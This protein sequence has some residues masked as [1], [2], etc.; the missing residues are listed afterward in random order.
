MWPWTPREPVICE[1]H[2]SQSRLLRRG[3][4]PTALPALV[5][6]D[7]SI[8]VEAIRQVTGPG[9]VALR[10]RFAGPRTVHWL[11][12]PPRGSGSLSDWQL[13]V[14]R[15]GADL[16]DGNPCWTA[17]LWDAHHSFLCAAAQS[18]WIEALRNAWNAPLQLGSYWLDALAMHA[19]L[20]PASGWL[21][22]RGVESL[23]LTRHQD[24]RLVA[25]HAV[26][27][28]DGVDDISAMAQATERCQQIAAREEWVEPDAWSWIDLRGGAENGS[29]SVHG[30]QR[31][32]AVGT[33]RGE[34]L[35]P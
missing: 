7:A 3:R 10:I 24:R 31:Q 16:L 25:L 35:V 21:V 20:A 4:T 9:P 29:V 30:W 1:L 6:L 8:L 11:Q 13:L 27:M 23:L 12:T 5:A 17:A 19:R 33:W 14:Q 15:R 34:A 18:S 28:P 2:G 32:A 22:M 26:Q